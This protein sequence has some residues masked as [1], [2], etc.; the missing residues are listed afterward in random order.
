VFQFTLSTEFF[1]RGQSVRG[2]FEIAP[3]QP[4]ADLKYIYW[5]VKA[6]R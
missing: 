3:V 5:L 1:L 6:L 2:H 4:T